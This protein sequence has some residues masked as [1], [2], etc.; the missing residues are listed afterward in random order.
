MT[1]DKNTYTYYYEYI[2]CTKKTLAQNLY[3]KIESH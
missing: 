2:R 3:T 1:T